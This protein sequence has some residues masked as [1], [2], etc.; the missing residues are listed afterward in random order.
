MRY[1]PVGLNGKGGSG[2]VLWQSSHNCGKSIMRLKQTKNLF[3]PP[4]E[5][6]DSDI[7]VLKTFAEA[8]HSNTIQMIEDATQIKSKIVKIK[9]SKNV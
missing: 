7:L 8:K 6:D 1:Y 9:K 4:Y 3:E 2:Y 5:I